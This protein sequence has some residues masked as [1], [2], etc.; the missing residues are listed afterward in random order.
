MD[1]CILNIGPNL[2]SSSGQDIFLGLYL[3]QS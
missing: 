2:C 3:L 1:I